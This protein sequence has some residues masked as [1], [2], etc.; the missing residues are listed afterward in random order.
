M[1]LASVRRR[2]G[3]L[4]GG[5]MRHRARSILAVG[6]L[7]LGGAG[8]AP[9]AQARPAGP[10]ASDTDE[11]KVFRADVTKAQV[12][13]LLAAGQDGHELGERVPDRGTATVEVYLTDGQAEKLEEQGVELTEHALSARAETRVQDAA[14][15]VFRPY[16]GAGGL[17]E[18][19]LR[20]AR[21][22]PDLTKVVSIG[23]TVRGQDILALKL[24]K[25]AGKTKDG[26]KPA[27]LYMSNQHAREWITPE[28]TRRLMHH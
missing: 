9:I 14:E 22:N 25:K 15:G 5:H 18:E 16:S 10:A 23:R 3:P 21:E 1:S 6:T 27:V 13:L 24:T 7:L 26:A 19:I 11:V 28:M 12:S 20:T 2:G 4:P 17:R 8:F